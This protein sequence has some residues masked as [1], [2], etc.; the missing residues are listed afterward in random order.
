MN[1]LSFAAAHFST[2]RDRIRMEDP[3]IDEGTLADTVEGLSDLPEI[4]TTILR[5]ALADEAMAGGLKGRIIEMEER[6]NRLEERA[7]KRR[8]I[9]KETMVKV[10]LKKLSAPDFTAT[11][12]A[13]TPSLTILDEAAVPHIYWEPRAHIYWEPREPRLNRQELL[14]ELKHGAKISGVTLNDPEPV[15]TVRTR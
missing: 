5:A 14:S 15:L 8:Q 2:I 4:L 6:L 12:R 11:V 7:T 3:R 9:V 1:V 10:D 13:G